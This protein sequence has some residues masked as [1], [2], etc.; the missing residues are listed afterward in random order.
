MRTWLARRARRRRSLVAMNPQTFA[1]DIGA[2]EPGGYIFYNST[3]PMPP[4]LL[5]EDLTV[6]GVPLTEICARE[7]SEPRQ[8]QLYKNIIYVGALAALLDIEPRGSRQA[9]R[10]AVQGQGAPFG[11]QPRRAQDR[12]R[13]GED[14]LRLPASSARAPRR[15]SRRPH[16]GRGQFRRRSSARSTAGRRYAPG[17]RSR[18][19]PR[20]RKHSSAIAPASAS[21]RRR[22]RKL[23]HRAG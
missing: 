14:A 2:V 3:K 21:I 17:T 13:P 11:R 10:R 12:L 6:L 1:Q 16:S 9:D 19:R 23:R 7:Y 8:R 5:R 4:R 18:S 15:G 20:S 22:A